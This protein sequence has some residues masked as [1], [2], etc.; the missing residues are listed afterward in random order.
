VVFPVAGKSTKAKKF[1]AKGYQW[2]N[3]DNFF[4]KN[5]KYVFN[6]IRIAE[7]HNW[8]YGEFLMALTEKLNVVVDNTFIHKWEYMNY[9]FAANM[10]GYDV[11]IIE[12][13]PKNI[14]QLQECARRNI[15]RVP[16]EI[17]GRMAIEFE[18]DKNAESYALS[19]SQ[20]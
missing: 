6:P 19:G 13:M 3:T 1:I 20:S 9:I 8:A 17:I 18:W 4:I 15:H 5:G 12:V 2:I 7:A 14:L 16:V 10:Q 11:R